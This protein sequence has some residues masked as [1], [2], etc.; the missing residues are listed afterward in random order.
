M[1]A[2]RAVSLTAAVALPPAAC[3]MDVSNPSVIDAA[4][5][6]PT[7]DAALLSLSAQSNFFRAYGGIIPYSAFFSQEAIAGVVRQETNDIARRVM[8]AGTLDV[9]SAIWVPLQRAIA[10]NEQAIEV[11]VA[12]ANAASDLNLARVLL[13]SG[14]SLVLLAEHFCQGAIRVGPPLTPD[15]VLDTAMSRFDDAIG[16]ATAAGSGALATSILN[17]ARVGLARAALQKKDY[18]TAAQTAALVPA[19]FVFN[20]GAVDDASNRALGN[21][22]FSFDANNGNGFVTA[23]AYRALADPRVPWRDAGRRAQDTQF[24]HFQQMKYTSYGSPIRVASGLEA[25]YIV[26]EARLRQNDA[27][28]ALALI[29]ERRAAN[30]QPPFTGTASDI[31]L[32]ELMN[33]R[34]REFWLEAKH[35]GDWVRNP[36]ATPFVGTPGTPYF[37]PAQGNFGSASCLP[38]PQ[39][40]VNANPNFPKS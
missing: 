16:V 36:S 7:S 39:A 32:A 34:A 6:D 12:G 26:A 15:Q 29:A 25:R 28:P 33:Q 5:F 30:Q 11:L 27:V 14:F 22:V 24:Q 1:R 31:V 18:A 3:D 2:L 40:E 20:A 9:N 21:A 10:T 4:T 13:S 19:T 35:T 38:V 17:A 23:D 8:T 37:K